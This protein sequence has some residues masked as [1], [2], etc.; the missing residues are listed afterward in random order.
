MRARPG[1]ILSLTLVAWLL[2]IAP[3]HAYVDPGTTG[4]I[5]S[6]AVAF[7]AAAGMTFKLFWRR[8]TGFFRRDEA[9]DTP[10]DDD[11]SGGSDDADRVTEQA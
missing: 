6:L 7:F 1:W 8:I 4:Y 5:F 2:V 9:A 3:A 11:P 10:Q